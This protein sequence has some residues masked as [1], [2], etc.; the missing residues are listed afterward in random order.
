MGDASHRPPKKQDNEMEIRICDHCESKGTTFEWRVWGLAG[1]S[2]NDI[3]THI[4]E[5]ELCPE[6]ILKIEK[7]IKDFLVTQ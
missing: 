7:M 5:C 3:L 6:C 1:D 2:S 4:I